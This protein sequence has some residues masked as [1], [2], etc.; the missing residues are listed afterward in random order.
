MV[1]FLPLELSPIS[2][3]ST[4]RGVDPRKF[5]IIWLFGPANVNKKGFF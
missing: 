5:E 2:I 3:A 1:A 4:D